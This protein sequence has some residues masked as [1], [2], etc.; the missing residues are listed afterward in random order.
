MSKADD[1][2]VLLAMVEG[3]KEGDL[4]LDTE[5]WRVLVPDDGNIDIFSTS[6]DAATYLIGRLLPG[7]SWEVRRSGLADPAQAS[8]WDPRVAQVPS[9]VSLR[10]HSSGVPALALIAALLSTLIAQE[11]EHGR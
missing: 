1:L 11:V 2:R 4:M 5:L 8:L 7:W 3:A 9:T 10:D 6:V